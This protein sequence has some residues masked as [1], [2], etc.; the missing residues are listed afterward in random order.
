MPAKAEFTCVIR[1]RSVHQEKR[2]LA[3]PANRLITAFSV[4]NW[5]TRRAR[6]APM[7]RRIAISRCRAAERARSRLATFAQAM[8]S[9]RLTAPSIRIGAVMS[10][11]SRARPLV[12][13]SPR[14][15]RVGWLGFAPG[16]RTARAFNSSAACPGA[17]P[18]RKRP[19]RRQQRLPSSCSMS[20]RWTSR[21]CSTSGTHKS[22]SSAR[23]PQSRAE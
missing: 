17:N 19:Y 5:R 20:N 4:S 6:L 8:S 7:A 14:A 11:P 12:P 16:S 22:G 13:A 18:G 9:T 10:V 1:K 3:P 21:A 2:T 23:C 15:K